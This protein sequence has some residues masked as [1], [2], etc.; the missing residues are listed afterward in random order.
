MAGTSIIKALFMRVL[1]STHLSKKKK[2]RQLLVT[3]ESCPLITNRKVAHTIGRQLYGL[4]YFSVVWHNFCL[5]F[6][7]KGA[8]VQPIRSHYLAPNQLYAAKIAP[9][10]HI[11]VEQVLHVLH[12]Q[13]VLVGLRCKI[14]ENGRQVGAA[15]G[16]QTKLEAGARLGGNVEG[17][18]GRLGQVL[19]RADGSDVGDHA[20]V[21]Q[22][23][24]RGV[25]PEINR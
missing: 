4:E 19:Q 9:A 18:A 11:A 17:G 14:A 20:H 23:V 1:C 22:P 13:V 21:I 12:K 2:K 3:H 7:P 10:L 6:S 5:C 15:V 25:V 24:V 8:I 16:D